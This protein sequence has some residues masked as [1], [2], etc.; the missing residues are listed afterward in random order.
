MLAVKSLLRVVEELECFWGSVKEVCVCVWGGGW[1]GGGGCYGG[2]LDWN[3]EMKDLN[4][5]LLF[6]LFFV[7]EKETQT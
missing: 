6:S 3:W 5:I 2:L 1:G 4:N 7:T